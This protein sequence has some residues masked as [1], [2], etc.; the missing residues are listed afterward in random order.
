MLVIEARFEE[1]LGSSGCLG[2]YFAR[3]L[4]VEM[5]ISNTTVLTVFGK[6]ISNWHLVGSFDV[7][8]EGPRWFKP[9]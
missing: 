7:G 2:T 1:G 4:R 8:R 3:M 9:F 6:L 5:Y